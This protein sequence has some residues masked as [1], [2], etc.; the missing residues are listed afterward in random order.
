MP[1]EKLLAIEKKQ[2]YFQNILAFLASERAQGK[3][4]HPKPNEYFNAF[5]QTSL[6][7]LKVVILG[8]DPYHG[9]G[10]AHG[11]SFSVP[12]GVKAPPSLKNIFKELLADEQIREIPNNACLMPW[13]KQGVLLL[14]TSLS[15]EA[16]KPQSHSHIGWTAFTDIVIQEISAYSPHV[17]FLLWG[18]HAQK[19]QSLIDNKKHTVLTTSHPSPLSAHRGFLGCKHFSQANAALEKHQQQPINWQ[20]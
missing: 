16:N 19:K 4:I 17:V 18:S 10:Q 6:K 2:P 8:Q 1:W 20:L 12:K 9:E 7:D 11:L 5:K 14:N 15:V 13:A 3:T